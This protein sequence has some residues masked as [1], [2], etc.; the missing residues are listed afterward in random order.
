MLDLFKSL[1]GADRLSH[2]VPVTSATHQE[3]ES[4]NTEQLFP[5]YAKVLA[6][7][8]SSFL[9]DA[10]RERY[11]SRKEKLENLF[12]PPRPIFCAISCRNAS[13]F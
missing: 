9:T 12:L 13:P 11:A 4:E 1:F 3:Q 8:D 2:V 10:N 7:M 6:R 5:G